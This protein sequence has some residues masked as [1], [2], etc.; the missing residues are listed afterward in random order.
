MKALFLLGTLKTT[1]SGKF[2]TTETLAELL[3]EKLKDH[4]VESEVV[5]LAD[6]NIPPGTRSNMGQGDEWPQILQKMFAADIIIFATPIWWDNQSSLIQRVV[7]RLD[8]L[9]DKIVE[10]GKS[11]LLNKVGGIVITGGED[12][13]QH[14]IGNLANFMAWNGLTLP[15]A[16]SLSTLGV[17]ADT[18]EELMQKFK[19]QTYT[20]GMAT[21]LARNLAHM[22]TLLKNNPIPT[23]EKGGQALR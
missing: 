13:A 15:P 16:P 11:E 2:S 3:I 22:A 8:E 12:G 21:T 6:H 19:S 14:I 9:N 20:V 5:K 4:N 17:W 7:E 10:T 23:Q 1:A 18:K